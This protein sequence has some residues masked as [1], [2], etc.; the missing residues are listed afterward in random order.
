MGKKCD[1]CGENSGMYPLCIKHLKMKQE[2]KVLKCPDCGKWYLKNEKHKC[3]NRKETKNFFNKYTKQAIIHKEQT[4]ET[5]DVRKKWEAMLQCDD[6]H[7]VRSYSEVLI[8][9]W[10]YHNNYVHAYEKSV[11][12]PKNPEETIISDFYIPQGNVYIEFWGLDNKKYNDRKEHKVKLYNDN[13]IN[14]INLTE[15]DIKILNDIMPKLLFKFNN[16]KF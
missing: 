9:N 13:E 4:I 8:D 1:I 15:N 6:G 3:E 10:L 5:E 14:L 2:N 11:F 12:M 16:K 7:Y